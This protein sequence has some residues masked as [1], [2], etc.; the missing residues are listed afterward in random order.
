MY[1]AMNIETHAFT[2]LIDMCS[3][4]DKEYTTVQYYCDRYKL[5]SCNVV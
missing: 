3:S 5:H 4:S 2:V 1:Q